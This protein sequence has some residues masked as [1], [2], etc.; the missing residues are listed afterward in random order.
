LLQNS[1][2]FAT[3]KAGGAL[4]LAEGGSGSDVTNVN[5]LVSPFGLQFG[6]VATE[7]SG[8]TIRDFEDHP[9][10]AGLR[11]IGLDFQRRIEVLNSSVAWPGSARRP[12]SVAS[13]DVEEAGFRDGMLETRCVLDR[14]SAARG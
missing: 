7:G 9:E 14:R 5:D 6:A 12:W 2:A 4:F 1:L 13:S 11:E 10:T 3:A 8:Q